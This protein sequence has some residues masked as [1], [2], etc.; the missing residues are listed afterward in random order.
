[1]HRVS[2]NDGAHEGAGNHVADEVVIHQDKAHEHRYGNDCADVPA[3]G[4]GQPPNRDEAQDPGRVTGREAA[5][6]IFALK[7][8]EAVGNVADQRRVAVEPG[9]W[10]VAARDI[11]QADAKLI[12]NDQ[13]DARDEQYFLPMCQRSTRTSYRDHRQDEGRPSL[14]LWRRVS[15]PSE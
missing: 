4:R 12:G 6:L 10:P 15:E 14:N 8:M 2:G 3:A 7:R 1:M 13:A 9:L 5:D 11:S